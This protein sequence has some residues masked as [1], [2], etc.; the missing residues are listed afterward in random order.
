LGSARVL[1]DDRGRLVSLPAGDEGRLTGV[2]YSDDFVGVAG[3]KGAR[4]ELT[5][6]GAP[7]WIDPTEAWLLN[8]DGS[9]LL[10]EDESIMEVA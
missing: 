6:V 5:V 8:D 9:F 4:V 1:F 10:N 2:Q 7:G 3:S